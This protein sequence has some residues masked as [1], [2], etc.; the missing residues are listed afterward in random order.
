L[1]GCGHLADCD[2]REFHSR[3]SKAHTI[4]GVHTDSLL[5]A[6]AIYER[7]EGAVIEQNELVAVMDE[8]AVSSGDSGQ[9]FWQRDIARGC[10]N[11]GCA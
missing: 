7:A 5:H 4:T 9:T 11:G 8:C 1:G 2:Q 10:W 3:F 6:L